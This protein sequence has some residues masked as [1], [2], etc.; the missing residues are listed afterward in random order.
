MDVT[1]NA[2]VAIQPHAASDVFGRLGWTR[3]ISE[4]W[5][6]LI[7]G[8]VRTLAALNS[9]FGYTFLPA[10]NVIKTTP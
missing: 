5:E 6:Y 8:V 7:L 4:L 10:L 3:G 9:F 2:L 1:V